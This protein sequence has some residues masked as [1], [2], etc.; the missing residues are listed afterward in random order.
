M[1]TLRRKSCV[2]AMPMEAKER[3]V[4]SQAR[5]VRSVRRGKSAVQIT[6]RCRD[7]LRGGVY[8]PKAK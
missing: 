5:N 3:L 6:P 7:E 2:M 8:I 1:E 4:R